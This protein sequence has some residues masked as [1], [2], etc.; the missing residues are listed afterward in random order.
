MAMSLTR[1]HIYMVDTCLTKYADLLLNV[2]VN[3]SK[4]VPCQVILLVMDSTNSMLSDRQRTINVSL[5]GLCDLDLFF[6]VMV[7]GP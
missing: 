7:N 5:N 6:K 1:C 2:T 4:V 3:W